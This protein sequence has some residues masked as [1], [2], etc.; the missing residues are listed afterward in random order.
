MWLHLILIFIVPHSTQGI[1]VK[2]WNLWYDFP[3][4]ISKCTTLM[5]MALG[6]FPVS[7]VWASLKGGVTVRH[8]SK[9][10]GLDNI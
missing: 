4:C 5:P 6:H 2:F 8:I 3:F 7:A 1:P 10:R 9:K